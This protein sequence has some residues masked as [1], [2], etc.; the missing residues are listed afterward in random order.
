MDQT[1]L[2]SSGKKEKEKF[3]LFYGTILYFEGSNILKQFYQI[4]VNIL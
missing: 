1:Q 3:S 2:D 4:I